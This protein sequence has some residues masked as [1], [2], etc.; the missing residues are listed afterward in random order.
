MWSHV[1]DLQ[2]RGLV[3]GAEAQ[4]I[5]AHGTVSMLMMTPHKNAL[6]CHKVT[7][8]VLVS[9]QQCQHICWNCKQAHHH[10]RQ[11]L[12]WRRTLSGMVA[13]MHIT[14]FFCFICA[15]HSP[16]CVNGSAKASTR[17]VREHA[18]YKNKVHEHNATQLAQVCHHLPCEAFATV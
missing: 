13:R 8:C 6:A 2:D 16:A 18:L 9:E 3:L 11:C 14:E 10:N 1:T 17:S 4:I 7:D 5:N 15:T 12:H